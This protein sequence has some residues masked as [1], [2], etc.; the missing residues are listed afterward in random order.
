MSV[1]CVTLISWCLWTAVGSTL[2]STRHIVKL[3]NVIQAS[4]LRINAY[5]FGVSWISNLTTVDAMVSTPDILR[6]HFKAIFR[7]SM[8]LS[9]QT[10]FPQLLFNV[11]TLPWIFWPRHSIT[12]LAKRYCVLD[13]STRLSYLLV[14]H[15]LVRKLLH[16]HCRWAVFLILL[17][18]IYSAMSR[19]STDLKI[20]EFA[21]IELSAISSCGLVV[22]RNT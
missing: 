18:F 13:N 9:S 16:D 8:I 3:Q 20:Y 2:L 7:F 4:F 5:A 10:C 14:S 19:N 11:L 17:F 12:S 1:T 6:V 21:N 22:I 15:V